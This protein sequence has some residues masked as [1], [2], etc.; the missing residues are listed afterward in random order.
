MAE[1]STSSSPWASLH[2][3]CNINTLAKW[4]IHRHHDSS[5]A[6]HKSPKS[7][8]WPNSWKSLPLVQDSRNNPPTYE[9]TQPVKTI[10]PTPQQH[11]CLLRWTTFWLWNAY[12][13]KQTCF[14]FTMARSWI[15]SCAKPRIL[16][17]W[18]VPGTHPRPGT[19]PSSCVPFFLQ[20]EE[21]E[22]RLVW[23]KYFE[24]QTGMRQTE[25]PPLF[26]SH[27][28]LKIKANQGNFPGGTVVE[29]PPANAGDTRLRPGPGRSHMLR[30][31]YAHAP[32]LLSL[33]SRAC[34]PQLLS[35][36]ATTTEARV[37]RARARQR[38]GYRNEKL[39]HHNKE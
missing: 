38:R 2:A 24:C 17:W 26:W 34:K 30:S 37:P 33:C 14:R 1:D 15:I 27:L 8:W 9:I 5:K 12:I 22:E 39:A 29:S 25:E 13:S 21:P 3:H 19:W 35:P 7:G 31:N 16:T 32:Q 4:Y 18:P 20:Q 11:S 6:D 36:S 28:F 23:L 10:P